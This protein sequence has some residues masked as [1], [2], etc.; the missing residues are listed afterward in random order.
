M[1]ATTLTI[2]GR[3]ASP[4]EKWDDTEMA[5]ACPEL[6]VDE[7]TA[8]N[9]YCIHTK[10]LKER[11]VAN[12]LNERLGLETYFPRL[13]RQK[14]IRRVRRVVTSPL[15]PRYLFCRFDLQARYRAVR[16]A[17]EV[18]E[19][20]SFGE[21]P[22]L[23]PDTMIDELKSWAG[24]TF[25][26]ISVQP[27]LHPGDMVEITD[28]PMRGLHAVILRERNDRDRVAVLLSILECGAQVKISRSQLTRVI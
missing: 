16:Y 22:A 19:I 9:W 5:A 26:Q 6:S 18:L 27:D 1:S 10:P 24:D 8:L 28:G 4:T 7:A 13:K 15:F 21:R 11:Q 12:C 14:T 2:L 23:V 17:P 3:S 20:V 25:D